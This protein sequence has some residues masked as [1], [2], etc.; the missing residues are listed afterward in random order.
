MADKLAEV[1]H[2]KVNYHSVLAVKDVSF[3]LGEREI[4]MFD[5][6]NPAKPYWALF[7]CHF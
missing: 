1:K 5:T 3:S 2:L 7:F 6:P 4:R